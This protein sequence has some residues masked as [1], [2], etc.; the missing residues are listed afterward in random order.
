MQIFHSIGWD[1]TNLIVGTGDGHLYVF[2]GR[3]LDRTVRA[4]ESA[5]LV[6][7]STTTTAAGKDGGGVIVTGFQ[8]GT[9]KVWGP[10]LV[11]RFTVD[12]SGFGG[13]VVGGND[14]DCGYSCAV[15]SVFRDRERGSDRLL[16]GTDRNDIWELFPAANDD[17]ATDPDNPRTLDPEAVVRGHSGK[18]L[19]SLAVYTPTST[20]TNP[21]GPA[22]SLVATADDDR[23]LRLWD[24]LAPHRDLLHTAPLELGSRACAFSPDG[25]LLAVGLGSPCKVRASERHGKWIVIGLN[26]DGAVVFETRD[27]RKMVSVM[28]WSP[29]GAH[30]AVGSY[31]TKVYLYD[32]TVSGSG[33]SSSSVVKV[34]VSL[35][36]VI[37][38]HASPIAHLDF[39]SDSRYM[40]VNCHAHELR[41]YESETGLHVPAASRLRD[42]EWASHTCRFGWP[43]QGLWSATGD[44][45][46]GRSAGTR[47]VECVDCHVDRTDPSN[48]L[49][50]TGGEDGRVGLRRYPSLSHDARG[51]TVEGHGGRVG[52]IRWADGGRRLVS[53][54][55]D[56]RAIMVWD[57]RRD[58]TAVLGADDGAREGGDGGSA[59]RSAASTPIEREGVRPPEDETIEGRNDHDRPWVA[60]VVPPSDADRHAAPKPPPDRTLRLTTVHGFESSHRHPNDAVLY[61][62]RGEV[63]YPSSSC[64]VV[65]SPAADRQRFFRGHCG[66]DGHGHSQSRSLSA[67]TLDPAR[68][69]AA[70]GDEGG[71]VR[72][73]DAHTCAPIAG[74]VGLHRRRGGG[75]VD[76]LA[77]SDDAT[78][79][80]AVGAEEGIDVDGNVNV[81]GVWRSCS[82]EWGDDRFLQFRAECGGVAPVR[83]VGFL[84]GGG[85]QLVTGGDRQIRFWKGDGDE[86]LPFDGGAALHGERT[87][88]S[89]GDGYG[90]LLCGTA[91]CDSQGYLTGTRSGHL[92]MWNI[93][94][95][96][97]RIEAHEGQ[98]IN[99]ISRFTSGLVTGG[100]HGR[101]VLWSSPELER[102]HDFDLAA[103]TIHPSSL[104]TAIH[105]VCCAPP[106]TPPHRSSSG[107]TP[108][109]RPPSTVL[110]A[111]RGCDIYELSVPTG[112]AVRLQE[113][114]H[115]GSVAGLV[116][117]PRDGDVYATCGDD[118]TVRI[119][120]I[121]ERRAVK[122]L[123]VDYPLRCIAWSNDGAEILVGCGGSGGSGGSGGEDCD[124]VV[125]VGGLS[126]YRRIVVF[127]L[128]LCSSVPNLNFNEL[129]PSYSSRSVLSFVIYYY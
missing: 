72:V 118:G 21:D 120:S 53:I 82:G 6:I 105:S 44:D 40:Q 59:V 95:V 123:R 25:S 88:G 41:F 74:L 122:R 17:D 27:C 11:L 106:S 115:R 18:T 26:D 1:G 101:I 78:R 76:V 70:S 3:L 5:V 124:G 92:L 103:V 117:H 58:A 83:F 84:S 91:T 23:S 9:V 107:V 104:D 93:G 109:S 69:I 49:V 113:G 79:L 80:V 99:H 119:W 94:T 127:L 52:R 114:H 7:D 35:S 89:G 37:D 24:T 81:V 67:L 50:A 36:A 62:H 31:D 13:S 110:I 121:R 22:S 38:L 111:T 32:V 65:Y 66:S 90:V 20:S 19:S 61:N 12:L 75:G 46:D 97:T 96:R 85:P 14:V 116:T 30:I 54:G 28:E 15:T 2:T 100:S 34:E 68:R 128:E 98:A 39:S 4:S 16:V 125:R 71:T 64:G 33:P 63:V 129:S 77:F 51:V 60:S 108:A 8:D 42:V 47:S 45:G 57:V 10:S 112:A 29:N 126:I 87:G 55:A 48:S 56:D 43:L 102:T 73:W 86:F